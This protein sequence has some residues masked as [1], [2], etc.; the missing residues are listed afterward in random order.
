MLL[1]LAVG[2]LLFV[3]GFVHVRLWLW[4]VGDRPPNQSWLIGDA[5]AAPVALAVLAGTA[6]MVAGAGAVAGQDWWPSVAL[7]GSLVS[8]ALIALVFNRGL[9]IGLAIDAVVI[10]LALRARG[11]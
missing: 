10:A 1:R 4:G 3:H 6:L 8:V 2:G 11:G 7:A 5:R 9:S